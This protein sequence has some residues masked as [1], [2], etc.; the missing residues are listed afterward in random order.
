MYVPGH[1]LED[2]CVSLLLYPCV[3]MQMEISTNQDKRKKEDD[4]R[5]NI[6]KG[7]NNSSEIIGQ[8]LPLKYSTLSA[9]VKAKEVVDLNC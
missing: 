3:A 6:N 7:F 4:K 2:L 8:E 1:P 5:E 9:D